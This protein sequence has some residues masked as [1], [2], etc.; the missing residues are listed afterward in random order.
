MRRRGERGLPRLFVAGLSA[1]A[2]IGA[3]LALTAPSAVAKGA[4]Y[5]PEA[6]IYE[7][8]E[9][10]SGGSSGGLS[11][12]REGGTYALGEY[13][14]TSFRCGTFHPEHLSIRTCKDNN[15]GGAD[16]LGN[17]T[18]LYHGTGHLNT[19]TP[20]R[21]TYS[22][23]ARD[24]GG[25]STASIT[26]TVSTTTT[27]TSTTSTTSTSTTSTSTT[28]TT[29]TTLP[30]T[31]S[32]S[33]TS[34][35][36]TST[37]TTSTSLT[38]ASPAIAAQASA[39]NLLGAPVR[40]VATVT[41]GSSPTGT[42][43]FRLF[44]DATC[45]TQVFT[46]TNSLLGSTATSDWFTPAAAGTYYWTAVYGG[47]AANNPATSACG[48]ANQSVTIGPFAAPAP[49]RTIAGDFAGAMTVKAG[50]HVLITNARVVGPVTVNPG[51]SL[52]VVNSSISRGVT[53]N[54]PSFFS[55]CG[56]SVS[57][58][59]PNQ[60]LGVSNATVPIRIGD[61]A[62]GCAGN[63]FAG[64][65]NLNNNLAVTL[66][67]NVVPNNVNTNNNGPGNTV[68]KANTIYQVLACVGNNPPP[69]N[70]GQPNTAASRTGQCATL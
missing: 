55:M 42:V 62:A 7:P 37:S 67:A 20:G 56:A 10:R 3:A 4:G 46:S 28:S 5:P 43:V 25:S 44:S 14:A 18:R 50:E 66:G 57:G 8:V 58:P 29:S 38:K 30:P 33:T 47:D 9:V 36:T 41:G 24:E 21:R 59:P 35:S 17:G 19:S 45:S 1:T 6:R 16:N 15:G 2:V 27:S 23:V 64:D 53:A 68:I 40:D 49:T 69:T 48:A 61:P 12:T 52:S 13:V 34:T 26:Y 70:A 60:A 51:G 22:V 32:T 39:S 31:T 11:A 54:A 63:H 65:V